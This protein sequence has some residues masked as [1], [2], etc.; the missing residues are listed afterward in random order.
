MR[1]GLGLSLTCAEAAAK[2]VV[3]IEER[4]WAFPSRLRAVEEYSTRKDKYPV[5]ESGMQGSEKEAFT[6]ACDGETHIALITTAR[7]RRLTT[8]STMPWDICF[9]TNV[10]EW[11]SQSAWLFG[12]GALTSTGLAR[13]GRD[14]DA[15]TDLKILRTVRGGE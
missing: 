12:E 3:R 1:K 13:K 11:F 9:W 10:S 4:R 6:H 7:P 5:I 8:M 15:T 2:Q 14:T